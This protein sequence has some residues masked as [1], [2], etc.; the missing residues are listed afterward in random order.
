MNETSIAASGE[1][2]ALP[3][4]AGPVLTSAQDTRRRLVAIFGGSIGNLIEWYDWYVYSTFSMYFA[5]A[6][7]PSG[8]RTMQCAA[9]NPVKYRLTES[10]RGTR[11]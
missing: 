8:D 5:K 9:F 2:G 10:L 3:G 11:Q 6:F 4:A 7:F 1:S